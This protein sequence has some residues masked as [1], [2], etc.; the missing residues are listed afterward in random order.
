MASDASS[1]LVA[2]TESVCAFI[3]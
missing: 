1:K 2:M 3:A